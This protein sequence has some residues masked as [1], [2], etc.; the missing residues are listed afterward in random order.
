[1]SLDNIIIKQGQK[2]NVSQDLKSYMFWPYMTFDLN[3][4]KCLRIT[5][6]NVTFK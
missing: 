1:M 2:L 3:W 5:I 4:L 6:H